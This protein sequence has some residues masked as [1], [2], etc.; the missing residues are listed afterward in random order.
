MSQ[1]KALAKFRKMRKLSKQVN[2]DN[3]NWIL[4]FP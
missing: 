1:N 4:F 3:L 2:R